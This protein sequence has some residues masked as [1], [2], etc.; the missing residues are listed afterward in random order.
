MKV[1]E[2]KRAQM[3]TLESEAFKER[4]EGEGAPPGNGP[5]ERRREPETKAKKSEWLGDLG[6]GDRAGGYRT[7]TVI[8]YL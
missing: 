3:R 8:G 2:R 4:N 5:P 7:C 6:H 1:Q